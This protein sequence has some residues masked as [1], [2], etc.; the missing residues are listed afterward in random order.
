VHLDPWLADPAVQSTLR[1]SLTATR[2][3]VGSTFP[4]EAVRALLGATLER[5]SVAHEPL[6]H[7]YR[8]ERMLVHLDS[9]RHHP[10][11]QAGP[12]RL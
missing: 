8:A 2:A 9:S 1:D 11:P 10:D 7:L 3:Q 12:S 5:R 6:L 4:A